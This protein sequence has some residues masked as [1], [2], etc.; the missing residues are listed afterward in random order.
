MLRTFGRLG[1]MV[2]VNKRFTHHGHHTNLFKADTSLLSNDALNLTFNR[3][4]DKL[5]KRPLEAH[6]DLL[7]YHGINGNIDE[8]IKSYV[9]IV[10]N[11]PKD[12]LSLFAVVKLI[13]SMCKLKKY[14]E[15]LILSERLSKVANKSSLDYTEYLSKCPGQI[16]TIKNHIRLLEDQD[17]TSSDITLN[18]DHETLFQ[19][20]SDVMSNDWRTYYIGS[21]L[22]FYRWNQ[23]EEAISYL[24]ICLNFVDKDRLIIPLFARASFLQ[25]MKRREEALSMFKD[26][27]KSEQPHENHHFVLF[28]LAKSSLELYLDSRDLEWK[29]K[30]IDYI[31]RSVQA[32]PDQSEAIYRRGMMFNAMGEIRDSV[33]D[34]EK[35]VRD[36]PNVEIPRYMLAKALIEMKQYAGGLDHYKTLIEGF[37][38]ELEYRVSYVDALCT[39]GSVFP[40]QADDIKEQIEEQVLVIKQ[41]DPSRQS[42]K[43]VVDRQLQFEEHMEKLKQE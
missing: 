17:I 38:K 37:P 42:L 20:M 19:A 41:L 35:L 40:G 3:S 12:T 30:A 7:L 24:D 22:S 16:P 14:D 34:L 10:E 28:C 43:E 9:Y 18:E 21:L 13:S 2:L 23:K 4:G 25:A 33:L 6:M 31:N 8:C 32:A 15:A 27:V 39:V 5:N 11:K 36:K 26:I 29:N 1:R